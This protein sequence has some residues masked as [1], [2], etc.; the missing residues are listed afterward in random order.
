MI[1]ACVVSNFT[2]KRTG[3]VKPKVLVMRVVFVEHGASILDRAAMNPTLSFSSSATRPPVHKQRNPN[4]QCYQRI[5]RIR[6]LVNVASVPSTV[7]RR[8]PGWAPRSVAVRRASSRVDA[9]W[10][11]GIDRR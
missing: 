1:H 10:W 9:L 6:S 11:E 5:L 7:E 8:T 2:F 4:K 3:Y